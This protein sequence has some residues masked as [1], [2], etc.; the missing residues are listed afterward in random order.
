MNN[1]KAFTLIELLVVVA[2]IGILAAV[3]VVAYNGYTGTA[4]ISATKAN[5]KSV[6]KYIKA[7]LMKCE[8]GEAT[9]FKDGHYGPID[10]TGNATW[11]INNKGGMRLRDS[12]YD[13]SKIFSH[14]NAFDNTQLAV[15]RQ[16]SKG[17]GNYGCLGMVYITEFNTANSFAGGLHVKTCFK[18]PCN[19]DNSLRDQ[20]NVYP[21]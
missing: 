2:I 15:Q 17:S 5:H 13:N 3:G 9:I 21:D 12:L 4:K 11:S 8:L 19:A 14:I 18:E 6:L 10:C 7:E 20:I 1:Q 16:C